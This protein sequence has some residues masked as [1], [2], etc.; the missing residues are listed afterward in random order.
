M[1]TGVQKI[2]VV[3]VNKKKQVLCRIDENKDWDFPCFEV[4]EKQK[5]KKTLIKEIM[6]NYNIKV[7]LKKIIVPDVVD[8]QNQKLII[9]RAVVKKGYLDIFNEVNLKWVGIEELSTK[10]WVGIESV[11]FIVNWL[12]ETQQNE[13]INSNNMTWKW[14]IYAIL[15]VLSTLFLVSLNE[16]E[17]D[18]VVYYSI[19]IVFS[20]IISLL[21]TYVFH[22]ILFK[23]VVSDSQGY[24]YRFNIIWKKEMLLKYLNLKTDKTER[25]Y[26]KRKS[27]VFLLFSPDYLFADFFKFTLANN[28]ALN[29]RCPLRKNNVAR[30]YSK[31]E[32]IIKHEYQGKK[33]RC[34]YNINTDRF[35]C[36]KHQEKKRLKQFIIHSNWIN[37]YFACFLVIVSIVFSCLGTLISN[38]NAMINFIVII[39]EL[40][41]QLIDIFKNTFTEAPYIIIDLIYIFLLIR[42]ISRSI[43]IGLAFYN[44]TVKAKMN[45]DLLI[46]ERST[47]LKRGNRISLAVHSY[48]ELILLISPLYFMKPELITPI[49]L[50]KHQQSFLYLDYILYSASVSAFNISFDMVNLTSL[51]KFI[52]VLQVFMSII[53]VVLS[54]ATYLGFKDN[55]NEFEKADW[56]KGEK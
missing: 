17:I 15:I 6:K 2:Q 55:M 37:V 28:K 50:D 41:K 53:L 3:I 11:K 7:S 16:V 31:S 42:L 8:E 13:R 22:F 29:Q 43:E 12:I 27:C 25:P 49:L 24:S 1:N 26:I 56:E 46:G 40:E 47:N 32:R 18:N 39:M 38:I 44:D 19:L 54:V 51:G 34:K 23:D 35:D 20:Y 48:I 36:E 52:H 33:I 45:S 21:W 14:K 9:Y 5:I 30:R 4:K 10:K